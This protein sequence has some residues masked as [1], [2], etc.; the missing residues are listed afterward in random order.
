MR[1]FDETGQ[2]PSESG[3]P[4]A[5]ALKRRIRDLEEE[6]RKLRTDLRQ[7]H[8][9][10]RV[11]RQ[12]LQSFYEI[13]FPATEEEFLARIKA[14]PSLREVLDELNREYGP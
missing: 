9:A 3:E 13:G 1:R 12:E 8:E 4:S 14:G 2:E 10:W 6:N 7:T 11:D 5:D